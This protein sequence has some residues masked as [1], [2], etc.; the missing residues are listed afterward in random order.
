MTLYLAPGACSL[1]PHILLHEIGAEFSTFIIGVKTGIPKNFDKVNQKMRV[2]VLVLTYPSP[3]GDEKGEEQE[4][5]IT[6]GVAIMTAIGE[7]APEKQLF[8][9]TAL[10][11]V[12]CYEFLNYL[13]AEVHAMAYGMIFVPSRFIEEEK[14]Q[15]KVRA[16]GLEKAEEA[17]GVIDSM[18]REGGWAVGDAF[19]V[20]DA[21][22]LVF[23]RWGVE[24]GVIKP[25]RFLR[26]AA[27]MEKVLAREA[28]KKTLKTEGIEARVKL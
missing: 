22:L 23:W 12:K 18:L 5:V 9:K 8:G 4:V 3:S 20:V 15:E 6:E 28:V 19:T 24:R 16:K 7:L 13:A 21:Y 10:E 25:G 2:P 14:M 26:W 1:A 11:K 17:Y 27:L